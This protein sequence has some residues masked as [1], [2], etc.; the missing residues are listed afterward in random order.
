MS[1]TQTGGSVNIFELMELAKSTKG[2]IS[3]GLGDPDLDTPKHIVD[4]AK[5]AID[6]GRTGPAPTRGLLEL[7]EAISRKLSRDNGIEADPETEIVVTTGGQ[8]A[9]FL[10]VQALIEPGDEVIVPDPR[11]TSYDA[12]IELAGGKMVLVPTHEE[13]AFDLDPDEVEKRITPKTK[14][15]L[16]ISPN[17]PTA[18]I[19]TPPN[20]RRL[21]EIAV[22]H[23]LIVISDEIYEKFLYDDAEHLSIA[24]LPG[25]RERTITLNG[26]SKTYAMTG[27]RIG[28]LTGPAEFIRAASALKQMVNVQA[29]TVSQWAA[30]AALNGPQEC[31][32]EMHATYAERRKLLMKALTDMGFTYGLP[33]GGLYIWANTASTGIESTDLSYMFLKEGNVLILP[34]TG[35]GDHWGDYMRVTLLQPIEI[36]EDVVDRMKTVLAN[37]RQNGA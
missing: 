4:A 19:V 8:E 18:G 26:V 34:G 10:L 2:A 33:R 17:N 30:T 15:L 22:K 32:A 23:D 27:W 6:E 11:Y 25:M 36:L 21:A 14:V 20:I 35:F 7:R 28:Y 5:A 1:G 29:P 13:D 31:V 16:M 37:H 3:M 12:A 24:T 9:L